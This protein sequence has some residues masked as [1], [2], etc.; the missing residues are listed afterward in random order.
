MATL[1]TTVPS[2]VCSGEAYI[3]LWPRP[4]TQDTAADP[5]AIK[6][7]C[8]EQLQAAQ[9]RGKQVVLLSS[10]QQAK[11][12]RQAKTVKGPG[13]CRPQYLLTHLP[14]LDHLSHIS[15]IHNLFFFYIS[16]VLCLLPPENL[17]IPSN[18]LLSNLITYIHRLHSCLD[19]YQE[20]GG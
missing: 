3:G 12:L 9:G 2:L 15:I 18:N 5:P 17:I 8:S 4:S 16:Y 13:V 1:D 20:M 11:G 6:A 19:I 14:I 7:S 10:L